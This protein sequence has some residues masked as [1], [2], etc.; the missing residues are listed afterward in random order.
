MVKSSLAVLA[1]AAALAVAGMT[2]PALAASVATC[3]SEKVLGPKGVLIDRID[4]NADGYAME[5]RHRGYRVESVQGWGGCV[6]A[7]ITDPDGGSHMEF[8]DPDTLAPLAT[9]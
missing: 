9:N 8:F 2:A 4:A 5:L 3:Q 7:F 1:L 6:K